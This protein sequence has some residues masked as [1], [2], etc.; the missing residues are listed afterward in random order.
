MMDVPMERVNAAKNAAI[1]TLKVLLAMTFLV[2]GIQ[3]LRGGVAWVDLFA[4]AGYPVWFRMVV[5]VIET[6][7]GAA[8]LVPPLASYA[9]IALAVVM[10][11]ATFTQLV[12]GGGWTALASLILLVA[13]IIVARLRWS[14]ALHERGE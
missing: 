14:F 4:M 12:S 2:V 1:W 8:L 13:L 10:F 11:G 5:G 6:V 9:A 7:C 3:K